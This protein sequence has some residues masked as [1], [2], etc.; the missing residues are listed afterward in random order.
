MQNIAQGCAQA[1]L[2]NEDVE[3][4]VAFFPFK[5]DV[6]DMETIDKISDYLT[7]LQKELDLQKEILT[8]LVLQRKALQQYLLNG[9][10]R[11]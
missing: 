4:F 2:S 11:V 9:I 8:K 6:L 1:N 3:N 10:V 7:A 5:N